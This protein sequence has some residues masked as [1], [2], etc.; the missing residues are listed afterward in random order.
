[1]I[2][3]PDFGLLR[4]G[5]GQFSL[6]NTGKVHNMFFFTTLHLLRHLYALRH[7]LL[8]NLN[9]IFPVSVKLIKLLFISDSLSF[10]LVIHVI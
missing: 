7:R 6:Y 1:M 3:S 10:S 9:Y 4:F 5:Y 2:W 8:I